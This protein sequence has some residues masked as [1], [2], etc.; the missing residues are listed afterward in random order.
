MKDA[1]VGEETSGANVENFFAIFVDYMKFEKDALTTR[2]RKCLKSIKPTL[3]YF[4]QSLF[5][6]ITIGV[7]LQDWEKVRAVW[8]S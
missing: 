7:N 2:S 4:P 8:K 5:C 1:P 3:S 6:L